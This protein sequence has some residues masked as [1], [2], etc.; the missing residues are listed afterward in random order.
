MVCSSLVCS[1]LYQLRGFIYT[2]G[3]Y[4]NTCVLYLTTENTSYNRNANTCFRVSTHLHNTGI[5]LSPIHLQTLSTQSHVFAFSLL[6][7][8]DS[9]INTTQTPSTTS[10]L[11]HRHKRGFPFNTPTLYSP[12]GPLLLFQAPWPPQLSPRSSFSRASSSSQP[13]TTSII[14]NPYTTPHP[15]R[16]CRPPPPLLHPTSTLTATP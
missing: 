9:I 16:N 7:T 15:H 13:P 2:C 3:R 11:P 14:L 12:T 4:A 10:R 1:I 8:S 6:H 5:P